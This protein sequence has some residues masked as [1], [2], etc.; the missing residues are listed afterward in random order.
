MSERHV[1][2]YISEELNSIWE[3]TADGKCFVIGYANG[4]YD[5]LNITKGTIDK[6]V[7]SAI[8]N[9]LLSRTDDVGKYLR[10]MFERFEKSNSKSE[11]LEEKIESLRRNM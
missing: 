6:D 7:Y 1:K 9:S 2:K 11:D 5:M 3:Q 8:K 4:Y 10:N